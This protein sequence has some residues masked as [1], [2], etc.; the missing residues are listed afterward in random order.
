LR[1]P[2]EDHQVELATG[3]FDSDFSTPLEAHLSWEVHFFNQLANSLRTVDAHF[4]GL[5]DHT[6]AGS[7]QV[8]KGGQGGE[9]GV[10]PGAD[11][12]R[13]P[14]GFLLEEGVS[15]QSGKARVDLLPPVREVVHV[16]DEPVH[17]VDDG[18]VVLDECDVALVQVVFSSFLELVFHL[19]LEGFKSIQSF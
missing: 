12:E 9:V 17:I 11:A 18:G 3:Q 16:L 15:G 4:G 7:N 8:E 19:D 14:Q 13:N 6:V 10:V 2:C 1:G 5:D